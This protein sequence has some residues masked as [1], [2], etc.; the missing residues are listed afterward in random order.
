MINKNKKLINLFNLELNKKLNINNNYISRKA[1]EEEYFIAYLDFISNSSYFSRFKYFNERT[2]HYIT[3]KTLN[4]KVNMWINLD[5]FKNIFNST[6]NNYCESRN[7]S[8]FKYLSEDTLFV[9]NRMCNKNDIGR[10]VYYKSKNG[11]K[12]DTIVDIN[13]TPLDISV[14][15]GNQNDATIATKRIPI[16]ANKINTKKYNNS[17]KYKTVMLGDAI[18]DNDNLKKI[19][20][21][22]NMN[23]IMAPNKRNTKDTTKL[24]NKEL[25]NKNKQKLKKR[26]IVENSFSWLTQYTPRFYRIFT[27]TALNFLNEVYINATKIIL[28]KF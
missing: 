4:N 20:K 12:I 21:D 3:G 22:N 23:S 18:Y 2:K 25:S 19:I 13:G 9:P 1:T 5:I 11:L 15:P 8:E 10:C 17:L 24:K 14:S 26:H 7:Q 6:S 28:S 27:R 16:I